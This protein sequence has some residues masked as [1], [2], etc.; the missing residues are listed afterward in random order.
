MSNLYR[1]SIL[2]SI[3]AALLIGIGSLLIQRQIR[4]DARAEVGQALR[5]VLASS[6]Q[7][8]RSWVSEHR[9]SVQAWAGTSSFTDVMAA[10]LERGQDRETLLAA[11]EQKLARDW[12]ADVS[13][14]SGYQ[15]FFLIAISSR[16]C[17]RG[18]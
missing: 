9:A 7:A 15:G 6:H 8:I 14:A 10:L 12:F 1:A 17:T 13:Q 5:T 2:L 4:E 16:C 11:V 3:I 18:G